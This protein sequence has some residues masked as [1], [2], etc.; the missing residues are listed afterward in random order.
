[1]SGWSF[2]PSVWP[3]SRDPSGYAHTGHQSDLAYSG[4]TETVGPRF[5]DCDLSTLC[6]VPVKTLG[7]AQV[8]A[9]ATVIVST[10]N[11]DGVAEAIERFVL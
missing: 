5:R 10:N 1:M 6:S 11:E 3:C 9:A 8:K 4:L 7:A 2:L